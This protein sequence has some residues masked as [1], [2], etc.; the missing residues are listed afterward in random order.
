MNNKDFTS[1]LSRRLRYTI[2]DT[3][4][5]MSSLL[6]DMTQEL[7]EGNV[8]TIQGFGTFEVKK[9]AERITVNPTTK[10]RM[11]VPPKLVLAYR[12]SGQLKEK[13]K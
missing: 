3:S 10:Q 11:L 2:K 12:P 5:L 6:S 1:E 4:E 7:Q 9:K 13:F 8:V